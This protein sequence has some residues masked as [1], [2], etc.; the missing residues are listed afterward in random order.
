MVKY[1]DVVLN[2]N[3]VLTELDQESTSKYFDVNESNGIKNYTMKEKIRKECIRRIRSIM[4]TELSSKNLIN[5][6][7]TLA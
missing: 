2:D 6:I 4:K 5:A 1:T 7:N 3:T